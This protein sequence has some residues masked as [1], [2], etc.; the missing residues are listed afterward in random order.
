MP[1]VD[2]ISESGVPSSSLLR[3]FPSLGINGL[4]VMIKA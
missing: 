3:C 1:V 4:A 2:L